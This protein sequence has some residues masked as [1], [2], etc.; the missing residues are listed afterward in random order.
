MHT[1][2]ALLGYLGAGIAASGLIWS[3]ISEAKENSEVGKSLPSFT[4]ATNWLNTPKPVTVEDL[5]GSVV[6]IHIWTFACINCQRTIP[7]VVD[8][9]KKYASQGLKVVGIHTPEFAYEREIGNIKQ[10]IASHG[11]TYPNAVDNQFT[12]WKAYNNQY[13]PH[14]FLADRQGRLRYDHIGEGEYDT[15]ENMIKTLL[16]G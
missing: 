13:W 8:W 6:L 3:G 9:S 15:T 10:A 4:G 1:R 2:R 11:I 5:K 16:R 7:Y 14:L 12:L